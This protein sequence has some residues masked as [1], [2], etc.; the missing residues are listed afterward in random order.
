M[1]LDV[2]S[3]LLEQGKEFGLKKSGF[4]FIQHIS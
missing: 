1:A 4:D 2:A 3:E